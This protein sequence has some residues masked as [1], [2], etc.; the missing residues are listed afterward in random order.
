MC[1][2]SETDSLLARKKNLLLHL[3]KKYCHTLHCL[4]GNGYDMLSDYD[5]AGSQA[6]HK[7][8]LQFQY[9]S[10]FLPILLQNTV[11]SL[12]SSKS[13]GLSRLVYFA[14]EA[15]AVGYMQL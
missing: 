7:Y 2:L 8:F 13:T 1:Y 3:G 15:V 12:F 4:Q 6:L 11:L 14:W 9:Y 5:A 10:F